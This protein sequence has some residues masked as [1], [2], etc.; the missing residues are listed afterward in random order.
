MIV[1]DTNVWYRIVEDK[2]DENIIKRLPITVTAFN[3][4]ELLSSPNLLNISGRKYVLKACRAIIN[5][6]P[7]F[8]RNLPYEF[9]ANEY[10]GKKVKRKI[11]LSEFYKLCKEGFDNLDVEYLVG[12]RD[13]RVQGFRSSLTAQIANVRS[14]KTLKQRIGQPDEATNIST[15]DFLHEIAR[16]LKINPRKVNMKRILERG[17]GLELYLRA[18]GRYNQRL[19]LERQSP[20]GNDQFDITNLMYVK[21]NDVYWTF[22]AKWIEIINEVDM[23]H[24]LFKNFISV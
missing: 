9:V 23:G 8:I 5:A 4:I 16:Q 6:N 11:L 1:T 18:R 7:H 24:K 21:E 20:A 12:L 22:D 17:K 14:N 2:I 3:I 10:F 19:S 15:N 13:E